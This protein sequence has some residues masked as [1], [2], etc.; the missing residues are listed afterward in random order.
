MPKL[1]SSEELHRLRNDIPIT[2]LIEACGIPC[3]RSEDRRLRFA[4]PRCSGYHTVINSS[5]NQARCFECREN[6]NTI[7]LTMLTRRLSFV[8]AVKLLQRFKYQPPVTKPPQNATQRQA[9]IS[10]GE[11]LQQIAIAARQSHESKIA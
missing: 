5:S 4:C 3:R 2:A 10:V 7:E 9:P 8:D 11:L 6:F 1:F